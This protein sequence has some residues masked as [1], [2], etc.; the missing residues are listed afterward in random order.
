MPN[1][2]GAI[3]RSFGK[4][5]SSRDWSEHD[6]QVEDGFAESVRNVRDALAGLSDEG[7]RISC[8]KR[9]QNQLEWYDVALVHGY[10]VLKLQSSIHTLP[11]VFEDVQ[12]GDMVKMSNDV[13]AVLTAN[14]EAGIL[15]EY[16][17]LRRGLADA[18][19][20]VTKKD[21]SDRTVE[22]E[23]QGHGSMWFAAAGLT[24]AES[25]FVR[26]D[27]SQEGLH[28][29]IKTEE[30]QC[31][32]YR[33]QLA[34]CRSQVAA[35]T[36]GMAGTALQPAATAALLPQKLTTSAPLLP[37]GAKA[38]ARPTSEAAVSTGLS[39]AVQA[40]T[41]MFPMLSLPSVVA[42]TSATL[43]ENM[44]MPGLAI[45]AGASAVWS[46]ATVATAVPVALGLLTAA[47][48][49]SAL[50]ER[51]VPVSDPDRALQHLCAVLRQ[52][53]EQGLLFSAPHW[54]GN[55]FSDLVVQELV[56]PSLF[57][58]GE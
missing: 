49:M 31:L 39:K 48:H 7:Y 28:A 23:V 44:M 52:V 20:R 12:V 2:G 40:V 24:A 15:S 3:G 9:G 25:K 18:E 34:P 53:I 37:W 21:A 13:E 38:M 14:H 32:R 4:I 10:V 29:Q 50:A 8:V 17:G 45:Q 46:T 11:L 30:V 51:F 55:H 57:I 47:C 19:M 58:S 54:N 1:L 6:S 42:P 43:L 26:L 16:D 35:A 56:D 27:W 36:V 5:V 22:C 33:R 41:P